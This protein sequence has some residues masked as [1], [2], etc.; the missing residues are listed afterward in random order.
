MCLRVIADQLTKSRHDLA[1]R[2]YSVWANY[3][4]YV[5]R[6]ADYFIRVFVNQTFRS[7]HPTSH[8]E[9]G[10]FWTNFLRD[11]IKLW[12]IKKIG[13]LI[14][15]LSDVFG[16]CI[17]VWAPLL[18]PSP[19]GLAPWNPAD[20]TLA[21]SVVERLI[22]LLSWLPHNTYLPPGAETVE[23][24]IWQYFSNKL[25]NLQ[26]AGTSHVYG[27]YV[28]FFSLWFLWFF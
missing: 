18:E 10:I 20:S 6:I 19:S 13:F 15:G 17:A 5:C 27:V 16:Q 7:D 9:N 8:I 22:R 4:D 2:L 21:N 11:L 12:E 24:L 26:R 23:T 25:V 28:R 3:L 14:L 1:T